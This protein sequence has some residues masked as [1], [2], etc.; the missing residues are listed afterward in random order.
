MVCEEL[1][2][3]LRVVIGVDSFAEAVRD[4]G[5]HKPFRFLP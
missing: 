3:D 1:F 2:V 5:E 4:V